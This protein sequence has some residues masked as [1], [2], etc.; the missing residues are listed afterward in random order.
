MVKRR[1]VL[2]YNA[3]PWVASPKRET[4]GSAFPSIGDIHQPWEAG[5]SAGMDLDDDLLSRSPPIL[6]LKSGMESGTGGIFEKATSH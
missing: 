4:V 1:D 2:G 6:I 5:G 3:S